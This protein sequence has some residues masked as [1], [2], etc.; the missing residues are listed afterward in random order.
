MIR[1]TTYWNG[2]ITPVTIAVTEYSRHTQTRGDWRTVECTQGPKEGGVSAVD[3]LGTPPFYGCDLHLKNGT[4]Y[5][6]IES[7]LLIDDMLT[8]ARQMAAGGKPLVVSW[9]DFACGKIGGKHPLEISHTTP[10]QREV[11]DRAY[12]NGASLPRNR[13]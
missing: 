2:V 7:P 5:D 4:A 1:I 3:M 11:L 10:I 12:E 9:K 13:R 8:R 6:V